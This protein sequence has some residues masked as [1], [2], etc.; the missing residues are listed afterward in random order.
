MFNSFQKKKNNNY[1][2]IFTIHEGIC[3]KNAPTGSIKR[4][5]KNG[6]KNTATVV[7][8]LW[9]SPTP[10]G[11]GVPLLSVHVHVPAVV[12]LLLLSIHFLCNCSLVHVYNPVHLVNVGFQIW[13]PIFWSYVLFKFLNFTEICIYFVFN[14]YIF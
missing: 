11:T 7:T 9:M 3:S 2:V 8:N 6:G 13:F 4:D 1:W 12:L 14:Y 5:M 10:R